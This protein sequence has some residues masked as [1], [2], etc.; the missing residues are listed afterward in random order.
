VRRRVARP[1]APFIG[2][3]GGERPVR[4]P[5]G[6]VNDGGECGIQA[7]PFQLGI[8][9]AAPV[10]GGEEEE[11]SWRIVFAARESSRWRSGRVAK[12]PPA[13]AL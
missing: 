5:V 2:P 4:R 12:K 9:G 6:E 11:A 8:E 3:R 10:A 1:K 13:A 7:F